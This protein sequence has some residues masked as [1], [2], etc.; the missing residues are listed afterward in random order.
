M[1]LSRTE[2]RFTAALATSF[3]LAFGGENPP[4]A[5]A[6]EPHS[7]EARTLAPEAKQ[8]LVL[9]L[10]R[11]PTFQPGKRPVPLPAA[12][13]F[14][15]PSASGP[16]EVVAIEDP[17]S[18]VFHK[19]MSFPG[20]AGEARLLTVAGSEAT[21]KTWQNR[22][23]ELV[24]TT[25]WQQD[26]GGRSSRIRDVEIA[27]LYGD[28]RDALAVAT[29]DQGVV[30][31]LRP[32]GDGGFDVAEIDRE[33]DTFVHEIEIGDVDGDGVLE[34]YATPSEPNRLDGSEQKGTVVRYVPAKGQGRVV[35]ADLGLRHAKEI[36]VDDVDGDGRDELYVA[37]EGEMDKKTQR[38]QRKVEIRRYEAGTNPTGGTRVAEIP[39]RFSRFLT[40]GDIEGDGDKEMVVA[41]FISG[42]WL[43]RPQPDG[44]WKIESI[45][46]NSGG[47]EHASMLA[48]L[49]EDGR[50][51]LY[52]ASDNEKL[53]R[54]YE[55]DGTRLVGRVIHRRKEPGSVFT[56]NLMPVPIELVPR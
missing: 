5:S 28:G 23:G 6:E 24:A 20:P 43:L 27:D 9:S 45:D 33:P 7:P 37:V 3:L 36:L 53:V 40:V 52:V 30:A 13:E 4:S 51:E 49:D 31:I 14:L 44:V 38:L 8:A 42:L 10:A 48:D 55:W 47:F 50:D 41:G 25:I 26:F 1:P 56:W 17:Q 35:V 32:A 29:H 54:R 46:R 34:V 15:V 11:F 19:A 12:L 21:V 22:D 18:N 16:W 39:D 2:R